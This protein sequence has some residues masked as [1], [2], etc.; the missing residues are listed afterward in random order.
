MNPK[1]LN[2]ADE[3][4]RRQFMLNAAKT[5]LG[6][7]TVPM[8]GLSL[9][10]P[11]LAQAS[12]A[13]KSLGKAEHVIFLNMDGGMSHIDTFDV[14]PGTDVQGPVKAISS[15]GDYQLS[16]YLPN[17]AK[18]ADKLCVI[19]SMT[20][21]QGAHEQA[22]YQLHSSYSPLGTIGHPSIGS[23]ALSQKGRL[24]KELPGYVAING[25]KPKNTS[26]G[27]MGAE[28]G[29]VRLGR[30]NEGLKNSHLAHGVSE[31][32]FTTRLAVAD[33]L[34][35]KFHKQYQVPQVTAYESLYEEAV[36]LMKSEDLVAFNLDEE[37]SE[38]KSLYGDSNFAQ[39]CLLSRRLVEAGVR[40]IEVNLGG[41]DSHYDNFGTVESR[42]NELDKAYAALI[43][44][45]EGKGLLDKT[46]VVLGTE[47][48]RSP[49]IVSSHNEGRDHH[50]SCFS[51]V[52]AG[53]G[54]KGGV[55]YGTSDKKG[56]KP[57]SNPVTHQDLNATI[58]YA[59]GIDTE[60]VLFSPSGRP[61][62]MAG[63]D[64]LLGKPLTSI[65]A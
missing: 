32:D 47:F 18:V 8:L 48:G 17:T 21:T 2:K 52:I 37:P 3:L 51:S 11:V 16:E 25:G 59:L 54:V 13:N 43:T 22:Q 45:L 40:Y 60:K 9:A 38:V 56:N 10:S 26:S 61:F 19:N 41:W 27:W 4:C 28:Y 36:K 33:I 15:A 44:D 29:A 49:E 24:N 55:K 53:G 31:E 46:L 39:G 7:S 63:P 50:P 5:Y 57:A 14:K 30:A 58:G 12:G 35:Q 6:V 23:W 64:K 1:E 42:C 62:R 34:N 20:S 65:F